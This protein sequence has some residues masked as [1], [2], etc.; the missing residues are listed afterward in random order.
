MKIKQIVID[1]YDTKKISKQYLK[2]EIFRIDRPKEEL[3]AIYK[4]LTIIDEQIFDLIKQLSKKYDLY[5]VA[6]ETEKWTDIRIALYG[7]DKYFKKLYISSEVGFRKP[8]K[9]I[10]NLF[11]TETGLKPEECLFI[12]DKKE[13]TQAAGA[14]GFAVFQYTSFKDLEKYFLEQKI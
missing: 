7:F 13:N 10:F 2:E 11:L 14:L 6:N 1:L 12:D 8:D 9:E 3:E 4:S 5:S